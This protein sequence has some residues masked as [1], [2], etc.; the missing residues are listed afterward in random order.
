MKKVTEEIQE[1]IEVAVDSGLHQCDTCALDFATCESKEVVFAIDLNPDA[2][3]AEADRVVTC[4]AY[5]PKE[6]GVKGCINYDCEFFDK[7][8]LCGCKIHTVETQ[9]QGA[10][11]IF[12]PNM[13]DASESIPEV[14]EAIN[15]DL[16]ISESFMYNLP[17]FLTDVELGC[18]SKEQA[19]LWREWGKLN[20]QKKDSA[21]AY[22][23]AIKR[24]E[25][26]L[27]DIT[28]VV[29]EGS[30]ERPVKCFWMFDYAQNEK[31]LVREDRN[32]IVE[33]RT[34]TKEE[35][36]RYQNPE[37]FGAET[38]DQMLE[39]SI[40]NVKAAFPDAENVCHNIECGSYVAGEG[41][42]C[43]SLEYVL[44]CELCTSAPEAS[45]SVEEGNEP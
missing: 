25:D 9:G 7:S 27:D 30:E 13:V 16:P 28:R 33:R 3:G 18:Y 10:C 44:E 12:I 1:V 40:A 14:Q 19:D 41:N 8:M 23:D 11:D 4:G 20:Q 31:V 36:D 34:L 26:K 24:V 37:L 43:S 38:T 2:T 15:V 39:E 42:N 29:E 17:V 5:S 22:G 45:T 21:K 35:I 32:E 6:S